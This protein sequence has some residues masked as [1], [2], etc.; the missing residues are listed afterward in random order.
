M[1]RLAQRGS[2][3]ANGRRRPRTFDE[4]YDGLVE[5]GIIPEIQT[6]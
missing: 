3:N 2:G 4:W 5:D 1:W 6:S